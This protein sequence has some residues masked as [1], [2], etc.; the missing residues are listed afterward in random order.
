MM[1]PEGSGLWVLKHWLSFQ[2][3]QQRKKKKS[4]EIAFIETHSSTSRFADLTLKFLI[5]VQCKFGIMK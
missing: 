5:L 4:R 1:E 3:I 2:I